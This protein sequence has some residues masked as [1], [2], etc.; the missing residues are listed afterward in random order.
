MLTP[1]VFSLMLP[2]IV[3]LPP[4][5][6]CIV[7]RRLYYP[8]RDGYCWYFFCKAPLSDVERIVH[9]DQ[10]AMGLPNEDYQVRRG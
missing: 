10:I 3:D 7:W 5:P 1:A 2:A 9:H 8:A 4:E 6:V